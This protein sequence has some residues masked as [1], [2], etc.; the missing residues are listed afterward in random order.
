MEP[1]E[2]YAFGKTSVL[3]AIEAVKE[4]KCVVVTDDEGRENEGDLVFAA[5]KVRSVGFFSAR[6]QVRFATKSAHFSTVSLIS[7]WKSFAFFNLEPTLTFIISMMGQVLHNLGWIE[8]EFF[9]F[10]FGHNTVGC[11]FEV[12]RPP[13]HIL[14]SLTPVRYFCVSLRGV[15]ASI[16]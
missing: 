11:R 2:G 9:Q 5:E 3:A 6:S 7:T 10:R 4:G 15:S 14:V 16:V 1:E 12:R 13:P 8:R